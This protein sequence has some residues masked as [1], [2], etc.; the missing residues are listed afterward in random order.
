MALLWEERHGWSAAIETHS[1][2]D[3]LVVAYLGRDVLPA[4]AVVAAWVR[5]L[6]TGT[7]VSASLRP[8]CRRSAA[9]M[10]VGT[11]VWRRGSRATRGPGGRIRRAP[12]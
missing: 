8:S 9:W 11:A 10:A 7:G 1:G 2:E 3:L 4:P 12:H 6:L 5:D